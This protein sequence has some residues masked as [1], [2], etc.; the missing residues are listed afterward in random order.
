[1][2]AQGKAK[3]NALV[4]VSLGK[5]GKVEAVVSASDTRV[6]V[7][8]GARRWLTSQVGLLP[9]T[10]TVLAVLVRKNGHWCLEQNGV[11][12]WEATW[13]ELE[14]IEVEVTVPAFGR[15]VSYLHG[16]VISTCKDIHFTEDAVGIV[17]DLLARSPGSCRVVVRRPHGAYHVNKAVQIVGLGEERG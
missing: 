1:V 3:I 13:P 12:R 5:H 14:V 15:G 7:G 6:R 10:V 2:Q 8:D 11:R 4:E 16:R 9:A 17:I